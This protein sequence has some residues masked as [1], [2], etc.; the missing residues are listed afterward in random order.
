MSEELRIAGNRV[1][2]VG[3]V[4]EHKLK[5][6]TSNKDGKTTEYING[7]LVIACG[8]N[9]EVELKVFVSKY[10]NPKDGS[11]P[12]VKKN[13]EIL[14]GIIDGEY[15]TMVDDFENA[16]ALSV[17]GNG[18][19]TA[20]LKE[21]R[22]ANQTKTDV[23]T[24]IS[25]DLGFGN[26][27]I[28]EKD[29]EK[30]K[31]KFDVEAYVSE[32]VDEVK[33]EDE[34]ETGRVIVKVLIPTAKGDIFP[35]NLIAGTVTDSEGE[36]NMGEILRDEGIEGET[37]NFWGDINY[38]KIVEKV[39][40]GGSMGR[41]KF[42][43]HTTYIHELVVVGAERVDDEKAYEDEEIEQAMKQ[44]SIAFDEVLTKAKEKAEN[45]GNG[46]KGRGGIGSKTGASKS[47][48]GGEKKKR[49]VTF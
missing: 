28:T 5:E 12:K 35:V 10:T 1:D 37:I 3:V 25:C 2:L 14:K 47:A 8:E 30:F 16:V 7:S 23:S 24:K 41:A 48:E 43:E 31:A 40:K 29:P 22:Y 26:I 6:G 9:K 33:G 49:T 38:G 18:N 27:A 42:E 34:E 11:Q 4:K 36:Y 44:R 32:L 45:E 15:P 39:K 20:Q 21:E 46:N 17:Y 19:F 13:Y